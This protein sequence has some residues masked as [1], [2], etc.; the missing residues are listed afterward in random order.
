MPSIPG[1]FD[2]EYAVDFN[3]LLD[4]LQN[5]QSHIVEHFKLES[6]SSKKTK[7]LERIIGKIHKRANKYKN[8]DRNRGYSRRRGSCN[9]R[10][11]CRIKTV[12]L[13][14]GKTGPGILLEIK[15]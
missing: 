5:S 15:N 12:Y 8:S 10:R 1:H 4:L 7:F 3:N 9:Y 2:K 6:A 11:A 13:V 14:A